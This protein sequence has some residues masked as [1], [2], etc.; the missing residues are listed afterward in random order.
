MHLIHLARD[1]PGVTID[2]AVTTA[3]SF[4]KRLCE[5]TRLLVELPEISF[6]STVA[7]IPFYTS[8]NRRRLA[9]D[10]GVKSNQLAIS[11]N[12]FEV[13]FGC[14][15]LLDEAWEPGTYESLRKEAASAYINS[16][17]GAVI[18]S[19]GLK[20]SSIYDWFK[21]D[22]GGSKD[23]VLKHIREYADA[24]LAAAIDGG[25]QIV[26]YDYDWTLNK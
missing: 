17:R 1:V 15:N 24:D 7:R 21:E 16:P 23:E 8:G 2:F 4:F 14:P 22:F 19:K 6:Q 18:T 3:N 12:A 13:R 10:L 25:A 11:S 26:G 20:I 5:I 9:A